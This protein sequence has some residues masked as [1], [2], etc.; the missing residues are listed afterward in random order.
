MSDFSMSVSRNNIA[1]EGTPAF[2]SSD[3]LS[4]AL[5]ETTTLIWYPLI[6]SLFSAMVK[7]VYQYI[8]ILF[9]ILFVWWHFNNSFARMLVLKKHFLTNQLIYHQVGHNTAFACFCA[10]SSVRNTRWMK[11]T[12]YIQLGWGIKKCTKIKNAHRNTSCKE[13]WRSS[14]SGVLITC[15]LSENLPSTTLQQLVSYNFLGAILAPNPSS[16][17]LPFPLR[18]LYIASLCQSLFTDVQEYKHL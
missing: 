14:T 2:S 11:E 9:R 18:L 10:I 8:N 12:A 6:T 17:F 5:P 16:L 7:A 4:S 1:L 15:L 13:E 3:P